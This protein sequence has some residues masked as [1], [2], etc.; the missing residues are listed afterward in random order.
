MIICDTG[1]LVALL[2]AADDHH[3]ACRSLFATYPGRLIVPG[4]I[5][6]EVC[7][8]AESRLGSETEA[9]FLDSLANGEFELEAVDASDL[10]R[11]AELVRTYADFPSRG[12]RRLGYRCRGAP[13]NNPNRNARPSPLPGRASCT[14]S[15]FHPAC[16]GLVT[17]W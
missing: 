15:L 4:P 17:V 6:T 3:A 11:M 13:E 8:M 2:N 12:S 9:L 14:L 10:A 16:S 1:A 5:L 7:Y